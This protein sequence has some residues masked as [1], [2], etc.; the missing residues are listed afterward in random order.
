MSN[1]IEA[2]RLKKK[3]AN[4]AAL[5]TDVVTEAIR[6][7][8]ENLDRID[9]LVRLTDRLER[10]NAELRTERDRILFDGVREIGSRQAA[11]LIADHHPRVEGGSVLVGSHLATLLWVADEACPVGEIVRALDLGV[12]TV[13]TIVDA[14]RERGLVERIADADDRRVHLVAITPKGQRWLRSARRYRAEAAKEAEG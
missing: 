9:E 1:D 12:A 4:A 3:G 14:L 7:R 13:S 5:L 11:Q 8:D 10:E 6:I 2:D